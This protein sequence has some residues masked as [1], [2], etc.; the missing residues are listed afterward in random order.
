MFLIRLERKSETANLV[1]MWLTATAPVA[2]WG[3]RNAAVKFASK[4]EA[5]R[6]AVELRISGAWYVEPV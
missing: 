3:E 4:G 6:A 1:S 2:K 5:R